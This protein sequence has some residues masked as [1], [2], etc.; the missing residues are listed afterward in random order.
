MQNKRKYIFITISILGTLFSCTSQITVNNQKV[1]ATSSP[2]S[3]SKPT[4][5][6]AATV[7]P[8]IIETAIPKVIPN[9]NFKEVRTISGKVFD[10]KGQLLDGVIVNAIYLD[11][12]A[13]WKTNSEPTANGIYQIKDV[14]CCSRI[15]LTTRKFRFLESKQIIVLK[16]SASQDVDNFNLLQ[17]EVCF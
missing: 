11:N 7:S 17:K 15:E 2:T 14:P 5:T 10:S 8:S 13:N 12:D 1:I 6:P 3:E 9:P 4:I 16:S